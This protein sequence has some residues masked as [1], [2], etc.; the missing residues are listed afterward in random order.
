ML[1]PDRELWET[2]RQQRHATGSIIPSSAI[3]HDVQLQIADQ[4]DAF[5]SGALALWWG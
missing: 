2:E 3:F 1:R 4:S 5:Q